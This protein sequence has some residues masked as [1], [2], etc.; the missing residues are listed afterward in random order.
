MSVTFVW[1]AV[2]RTQT[3]LTLKEAMDA[4][5][6]MAIQEMEYTAQVRVWKEIFV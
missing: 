3:A 4:D 5:V 2:M 1:I 6:M